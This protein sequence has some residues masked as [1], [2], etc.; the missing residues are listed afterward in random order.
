MHCVGLTGLQVMADAPRRSMPEAPLSSPAVGTGRVG[1]LAGSKVS[2]TTEVAHNCQSHDEYA[3]VQR[4]SAEKR[5]WCCWYHHV[6][7]SATTT[8]LPKI[9]PGVGGS[10]GTSADSTEE[11]LEVRDCHALEPSDW[12]DGK[13]QWCCKYFKW[14]CD[15]PSLFNCHAGLA[16]WQMRWSAVKRVW[17]CKHR[18][19]GCEVVTTTLEQYNC[20]LG[21]LHLDMGWSSEKKSWCCWHHGVG[22]VAKPVSTKAQSRTG[23]VT[24]TGTTSTTTPA[25]TKPRVT[26]AYTTSNAMV[27]GMTPSTRARADVIDNNFDGI[28]GKHTFN[29][30][31]DLAHWQTAWDEPKRRWCCDHFHWGCHGSSSDSAVTTTT[32]TRVSSS[33]YIVGQEFQTTR[34]FGVPQSVIGAAS[35]STSH[36]TR[37]PQAQLWRTTA[38]K[39]EHH[40]SQ[41]G[42]LQRSRGVCKSLGRVVC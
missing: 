34:L 27:G 14:D 33:T 31:S 6:G 10:G 1:T 20:T 41:A 23:K 39:G 28:V 36:V 15:H 2:S 11:K 40:A 22:C 19:Q 9:P 21:R 17:C 37:L 13:L 3:S 25:F 42:P 12:S 8:K 29:C 32:K 16:S 7:C 24:T 38:L 35:R 30:V 4:W 18:Q 26:V 5:S